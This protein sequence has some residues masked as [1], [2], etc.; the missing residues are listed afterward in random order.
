MRTHLT[1][2][3]VALVAVAAAVCSSSLHFAQA[4]YDMPDDLQPGRIIDRVVCKDAPNHSYAL[5]LPSTYSSAKKWPLIAAFDPGAR[6][7]VPVEHLKEAAER[8]GYIVC[9]SSTSRNGPLPPS[10]EAAKSMLVD[11]AAR[12]S[13]DERECT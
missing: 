3:C 10:A 2:S 11:V 5:Y 8:Y 7:N 4:S 9:G 1:L 6:G 13:I 12:F